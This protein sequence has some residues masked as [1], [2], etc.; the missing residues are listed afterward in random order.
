MYEGYG[1]TSNGADSNATD[2]RGTPFLGPHGS[3]GR[4]GSSRTRDRTRCHPQVIYKVPFNV[5]KGQ[6]RC[7]REVAEVTVPRDEREGGG[8]GRW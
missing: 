8:S 5:D 3:R 1:E 6:V 2:Y 4:T 7:V